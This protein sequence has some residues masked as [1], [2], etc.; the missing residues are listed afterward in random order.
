MSKGQ[1][2]S[3]KEESRI[4]SST[5]GSEVYVH[6]GLHD[7]WGALE[8]DGLDDPDDV[9]DIVEA[10]EEFNGPDGTGPKNMAEQERLEKKFITTVLARIA[11]AEGEEDVANVPESTTSDA[12]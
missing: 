1:G 3:N 10:I 12:A 4:Y 8:S 6:S 5:R 2:M 9:R 7:P 11:L